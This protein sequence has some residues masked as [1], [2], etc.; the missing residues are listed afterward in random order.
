VQPL[1]G[2]AGSPAVLAFQRREWAVERTAW[3]VGLALLAA[4]ALGLFGDGPLARRTASTPDGRL[5]VD[6]DRFARAQA[7]TTLRVRVEPP[8]AVGALRLALDRAYVE[9]VDVE[10]VVPRPQRVETGGEW[11]TWVFEVPAPGPATIV[12]RLQ[13]EGPGRPTARLRLGDGPALAFTAL[14]YP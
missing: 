10:R 12:F 14:V 6:F 2:E 9:G 4:A 11:I 13:H 5:A 8:A 3:A 7:P 1:Q